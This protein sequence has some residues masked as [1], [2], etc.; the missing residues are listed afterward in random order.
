LAVH[1]RNWSNTMTRK[2]RASRTTALP[3]PFE[4]AYAVANTVANCRAVA[5]ALPACIPDSIHGFT[6]D[7]LTRITGLAEAISHLMRHAENCAYEL[8]NSLHDLHLAQT[9]GE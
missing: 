4:R 2:S 6:L 5:E 8:G 7:H 9:K 1:Y 3:I